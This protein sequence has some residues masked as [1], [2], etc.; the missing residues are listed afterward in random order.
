MSGSIETFLK[1]CNFFLL[2]LLER[3]VLVPNGRLQREIADWAVNKKKLQALLFFLTAPVSIENALKN[4]P[5][6]NEDY[7]IKKKHKMLKNA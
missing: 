3:V 1:P 6:N 4:C 7:S 2:L 5:F